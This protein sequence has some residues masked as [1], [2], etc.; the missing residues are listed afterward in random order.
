MPHSLAVA[1]LALSIGACGNPTSTPGPASP[2]PA[3]ALADEIAQSDRF[4]LAH[5]DFAP[6]NYHYDSLAQM[7]AD[8]H[9]IVRGRLVGT[10]A[11][12][13]QPFNAP[14]GMDDA[15]R[16]IFGV[17]AIDEVLKGTPNTLIPGSVLVARLG[18]CDQRPEDLPRGEVLLFL[19][20][21]RQMRLETGSGPSS[22][23]NDGFYY[24]RPNGYQGVLRNLG[25]VVRIVE[26][27][28]DS[29]ELLEGFPLQLNHEPFA[30]VVA[31]VRQ[32][33]AG[34]RTSRDAD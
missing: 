24:A 18:A 17:V 30:D 28:E 12:T 4:W 13:L 5:S 7:T 21:Y 8:A 26:P 3:M 19:K 10:H 16:V 22:D 23:S 33:A 34:E 11:G 32:A 14:D 1:L 25:G 27:A 29:G 2:M 9:L 6:T 20:N 15:R 31:A